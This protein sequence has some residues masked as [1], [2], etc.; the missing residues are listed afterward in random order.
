MG[1]LGKIAG[2]TEIISLFIPILLIGAYFGTPILI[3]YWIG[4][5]ILVIGFGNFFL[6]IFDIIGILIALLILV[7]GILCI[8]KEGTILLISGL[9]TL[10]LMHFYYIWMVNSL[11][12][13]LNFY[14]LTN[15]K[16]ILTPFISFYSI[17]TS[18]ILAIIGGAIT[19][20]K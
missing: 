17:I 6:F 9:I 13:T 11:Y 8:T 4:G 19:I 2:I 16:M 3:F 10:F 5:L 12:F 14:K 7:H 18:S 20:K 1:K 15:N